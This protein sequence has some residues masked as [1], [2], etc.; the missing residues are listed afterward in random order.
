M[1]KIIFGITG[2]TIGGAE[3]VLVDLANELSKDYKITIFTL[4]AKGELEKQLDSN[5]ELKSLYEK[6][7]KELSKIKQKVLVPL[8]VL[9]FKKSIYNKKIKEDFDTEIAFLEGPI[10]R[11]FSCKNKNVRKIAWIHND[12]SQVFGQDLKAK[13]KKHLD[14]KTYEKYNDLVFVSKDNL[15]KFNKVYKK[16][17]IT[18]EHKKVIYNYIDSKRIIEKSKEK[19]EKNFEKNTINFVSV[20]RLVNQKGIDRLIKIH[21]KLLKSGYNHNIYVIGDGPQ[22]GELEELI[23]QEKV[24]K[25]FYL[26][27]QKENPYPYI[28]NA[29]YFC[30]LSRYEGYGMVLE[31]AKILNKKIVITNTAARE[32][33]QNYDNKWILENTNEG[34]YRGL[35]EIINKKTKDMNSENEKIET[36]YD[37]SEIIEKVKELIG[38]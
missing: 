3:R 1:K 7:Y 10:T 30:L 37:N 28:K 16:L 21:S 4:Y 38:D 24:E 9:L 34:I 33:V 12:I 22:R 17:K 27:G 20:A 6:Q 29:D 5:I 11:I 32:A 26:L 31:E 14:K 8:K 25:T 35:I 23:K 15:D 2:L 18:K 19:I 13:I 36:K